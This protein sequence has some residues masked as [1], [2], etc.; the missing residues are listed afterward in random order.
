MFVT[1]SV[2]AS[3][4]KII[5]QSQGT[6]LPGA[7]FV[8]AADV[9]AERKVVANNSDLMP[10]V[11]DLPNGRSA[12]SVGNAFLVATY[13]QNMGLVLTAKHVVMQVCSGLNGNSNRGVFLAWPGPSLH[14]NALVRVHSPPGLGVQCSQAATQPSPGADLAFLTVD[15]SQFSP[16][17]SR[18][19]P[20]PIASQSWDQGSSLHPFQSFTVEGYE[21]KKHFE[22]I[23]S[24]F[25]TGSTY[26]DTA[27]HQFTG[28]FVVG[29][30]FDPGY[31]G[32][33]ILGRT[34]SGGYAVVGAATN[35]YPDWG[36]QT[37]SVQI[38][39][40]PQLIDDK[41]R[42]DIGPV[43][44][45]LGIDL[46][47]ITHIMPTLP[48]DNLVQQALN[49]SNGPMSDDDVAALQAVM[50]GL[51]TPFD[52]ALLVAQYADARKA[53]PSA[54][55]AK[56]MFDH[57]MAEI[58]SQWCWD[59]QSFEKF[60]KEDL[61]QLAGSSPANLAAIGV[62]GQS[63]LADSNSHPAKTNADVTKLRLAY[64]ELSAASD[65]QNSTASSLEKDR[66]TAA[67]RLAIA[68]PV[69]SSLAI[70]DKEVPASAPIDPDQ[71]G[72]QKA[73]ADARVVG[74]QAT[75]DVNKR[76]QLLQQASQQYNMILESK[77]ASPTTVAA[78][79]QSLRYAKTIGQLGIP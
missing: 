34:A 15:L 6:D 60:I 48:S 3:D 13:G 77:E 65:A 5:D 18:F 56:V 55:M 2:V 10:L 64:A 19:I 28:V 14:P 27:G 62:S 40:V 33:A 74:A 61:N 35:F 26:T 63:L 9:T 25:A 73:A 23:T 21:P 42:W 29:T 20:L 4:C 38:E 24:Q 11:F 47:Y 37:A 45:G 69:S 78:S 43:L 30:S 44:K 57:N 70:L 68:Q 32:A 72:L 46:R 31:S 49:I 66:V 7:L 22:R 53:S 76:A 8:V 54:S 52:Q 12:I 16:V 39:Y 1:T 71:I 50:T 59:T 51:T 79:I 75:A 17:T 41:I 58:E 67:V 36:T